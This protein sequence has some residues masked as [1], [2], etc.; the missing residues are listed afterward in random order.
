MNKFYVIEPEKGMLFGTKWS[1]GEVMDPVN[2]GSSQKCPV[3]GGQVSKLKWLPPHFVKLSS[4]KPKKW[5]DFI[6]GAGFPLLISERFKEIYHLE[7]LKGIESFSPVEIVRMGKNKTG[8]FPLPPPC[9]YLVSI[10]W[11]GA[12][13]DDLAS[14]IR[15]EH[16]EEI[17]CNYCREG[18]AISSQVKVI[19]R[20]DSWDGSDI[21]KPIHAPTLFMASERFKQVAEKYEFTNIWLIPAEKYGYSELRHGTFP[22]FINESE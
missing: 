8:E 1:Y 10:P 2:Y 12:D 5:C 14:E 17:K 7:G 15:Y 21:F 6:W 3:C 18:V 13:Q 11:G 19:I 22:W 16:P 4:G 20:E 9:Y